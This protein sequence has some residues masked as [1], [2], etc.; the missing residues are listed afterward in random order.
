MPAVN[1]QGWKGSAGVPSLPTRGVG[2]RGRCACVAPWLSQERGDALGYRLLLLEG[3]GGCSYPSSLCGW[4]RSLLTCISP[5]P[6]AACGEGQGWHRPSATSQRGRSLS[7]P[8]HHPL[9]LLCRAGGERATFSCLTAFPMSP[10][11][12]CSLISV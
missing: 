6:L 4:L 9:V 10:S 1:T 7:L 3:G 5:L 12:V 11:W 2:G 8:E